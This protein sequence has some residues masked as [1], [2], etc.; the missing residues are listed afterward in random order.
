MRGAEKLGLRLLKRSSKLLR[1][2]VFYRCV[3]LFFIHRIDFLLLY[4][5]V[6]K[7]NIVAH[8][9]QSTWCWAFVYCPWLP[10]SDCR[11]SNCFTGL[12]AHR[13]QQ[14]GHVR[15]RSKPFLGRKVIYILRELLCNP[16]TWLSWKGQGALE[17]VEMPAWVDRVSLRAY[18]CV[19]AFRTRRNVHTRCCWF[20]RPNGT[21]GLFQVW[22]TLLQEV[23]VDSAVVADIANCLNRQVS[24]P[25]V[26]GTFHRKLE[27]RKIFQHREQ[28]ENA[29]E[30]ASQQLDKVS[31]LLRQII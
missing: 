7:A 1:P 19:R 10:V 4:P 17:A 26:D 29:L 6:R 13:N 2:P 5:P 14:S 9:L 20:N 22:E 16:A 28:L 27:A 3:E 23:E 31:Y 8:A 21:Y 24:R 12:S 11:R 18:L 25:M 30:K 15:T